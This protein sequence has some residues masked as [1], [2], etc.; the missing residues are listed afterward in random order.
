MKEAVEEK[1]QTRR[2]GRS[3]K[4]PSVEREST[5]EI[6]AMPA[7]SKR[8]TRGRKATETP[9][10]P[11]SSSEPQ[12]KK[13]NSRVVA[14]KTEE[15]EEVPAKRGKAEKMEEPQAKRTRRGKEPSVEPEATPE[16]PAK[17]G[18]AKKVTIMTPKT[19]EAKRVGKRNLP[20]TS[21]A[22]KAEEPATKRSTRSRK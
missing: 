10:E 2:G 14:K 13:T 15:A 4:E 21:A 6:P 22:E 9:A 17:R 18:A 1:T 7:T 19:E 8:A 11:E 5:P 12:L 20:T 3:A 16:V